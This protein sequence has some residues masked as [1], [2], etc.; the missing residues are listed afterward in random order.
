MEAIRSNSRDCCLGQL[1][2]GFHLDQGSYNQSNVYLAALDNGTFNDITISTKEHFKPE[3]EQFF[4]GIVHHISR[5]QPLVATEFVISDCIINSIQKKC[6]EEPQRSRQAKM[7]SL[8]YLAAVK[9]DNIQT[10]EVFSNFTLQI[11]RKTYSRVGNYTLCGEELLHML[12]NG[13]GLSGSQSCRYSCLTSRLICVA[14]TLPPDAWNTAF[15]ILSYF[16][17]I[18]YHVASLSE[19]LDSSQHPLNSGIDTSSVAIDNTT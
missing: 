16:L 9:I 15:G 11:H 4:K 14:R 3:Y 2:S 12:F 18:P 8:I 17:G 6:E 1:D 10:L 7:A 13:V 19:V 5:A